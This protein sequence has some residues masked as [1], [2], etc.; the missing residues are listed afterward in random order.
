[1]TRPSSFAEYSRRLLAFI[2][3]GAV[4]AEMEFA[5]LARELFALQFTHVAPYRR[6]CEARRVTPDS[7]T[8]WR[9]IPA[10]PTT[11]F[12]ELELTSLAPVER[13]TVFHS[14]GTTEHR[15]SRHF[16]SAES[17]AVYE[18]SLLPWFA[19]HLMP[20]RRCPTC[21]LPASA[22]AQ[23]GHLRSTASHTFLC[24]AP[25]P[26]Q[27]PHSSLAHMFATASHSLGAAD[28]AFLAT[29]GA[30]NSWSLDRAAALAA[31][32]SSGQ[33]SQPIVLLGTAFMFVH[34][35]DEL[36]RRGLSLALPPGSRVMETGGYKARSRE[37]PKAELHSLLTAR[38]GVPSGFIVCE[39]GMSELSSQAYDRVAGSASILSPQSSVFSFPPWCRALVISPETG[40]EVAEGETGLLRLFDL[41]NVRSVMAIQTEDLAVRRGDGF[42]LLGRAAQTEARGCSL[43]AA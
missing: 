28:S 35:L 19:R 36:E 34:L 32:R 4:A 27:A 5:A 17:L 31:L 15:P 43:L 24:L 40:R 12:K 8:D 13:T 22:S 2:E 10:V 41:A 1:M 25:P 30:D 23:V 3:R 11:A 37:L 29:A 21:E 9:L 18:A 7:P 20:E 39:Y 42:E 38:L 26:E 14:S 33:S 16:H 6:L